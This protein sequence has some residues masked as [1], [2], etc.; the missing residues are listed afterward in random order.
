MRLRG[1]YP[2]TCRHDAPAI[3]FEAQT[4]LLCVLAKS[5]SGPHDLSV[6]LDEV[7][8]RA[9]RTA[10][11]CPLRVPYTPLTVTLPNS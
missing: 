9:F 3:C 5:I 10:I 7:T 2:I 1:R 11:E 4:T 8:A 6:L